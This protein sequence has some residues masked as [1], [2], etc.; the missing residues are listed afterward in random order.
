MK[1]WISAHHFLLRRVVFKL[2]LEFIASY[3][4]LVFS[5]SVIENFFT[6]YKLRSIPY[7]TLSN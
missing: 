4:Y 7:N 3:I 5:T 1:I 6:Y 2:L